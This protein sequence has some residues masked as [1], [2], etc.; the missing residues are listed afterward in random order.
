MTVLCTSRSVAWAEVCSH[1][2]DLNAGSGEAG[3]R[4]DETVCDLSSGRVA[5]LGRV[6]SCGNSGC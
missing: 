3:G 6:T 5:L 2:V 1:C 4:V